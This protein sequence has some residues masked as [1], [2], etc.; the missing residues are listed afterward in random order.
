MKGPAQWGLTLPHT[1]ASR[2]WVVAEQR[3]AHLD[4]EVGDDGVGGAALGSGSGLQAL[5]DR[6]AAVSETLEIASRPGAGTVLRARLPID[7]R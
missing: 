5:R 3:N 4:V 2:A 7:G 6:V 1:Q